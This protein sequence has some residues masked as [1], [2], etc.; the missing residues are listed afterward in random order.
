[1]STKSVEEWSGGQLKSPRLL[2]ARRFGADVHGLYRDEEA[3]RSPSFAILRAFLEGNL[4]AKCFR[5]SLKW[6]VPQ[7]TVPKSRPRIRM[8]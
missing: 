6:P 8:D 5:D 1:M 3:P 2:F 4:A 7:G